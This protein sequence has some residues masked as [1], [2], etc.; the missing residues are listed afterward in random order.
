MPTNG[1]ESEPVEP[2]FKKKKNDGGMAA[3]NSQIALRDD[4]HQQLHN[5]YYHRLL[6]PFSMQYVVI[7]NFP[8]HPNNG[9]KDHA[10][11]G[12]G[13]N[14][15]DG[16]YNPHHYHIKCPG[17]RSVSGL[18]NGLIAFSYVHNLTFLNKTIKLPYYMYPALFISSSL[19]KGAV[20]LCISIPLPF[21][22]WQ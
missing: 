12:R 15:S 8:C 20:Q 18:E 1:I 2:N 5:I 10:L 21:S 14:R 16:D 11:V 6:P 3:I 7:P 9:H 4:L 13:I 22:L 19:V 17:I